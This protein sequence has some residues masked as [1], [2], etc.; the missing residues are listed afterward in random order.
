MSLNSSEHIQRFCFY[1][2]T[3]KCSDAIF[4]GV[5][6]FKMFILL[7]MLEIYYVHLE[8]GKIHVFFHIF[9]VKIYNV[10]HEKKVEK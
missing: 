9:Y 3:Q 4:F 1:F 10:A 7:I 5:M 2:I 8:Q 6:N